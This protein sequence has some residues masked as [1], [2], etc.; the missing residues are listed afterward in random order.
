MDRELREYLAIQSNVRLDE[1]PHQYG[2]LGSV[3]PRGRPQADDPEFSK[4]PLPHPPVL[5]GVTHRPVD[6][7]GSLPD[8]PG[9][10]STETLGLLEDLVSSLAGFRPAFCAWHI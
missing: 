3:L 2:I 9:L 7:L 6:R 4:I 1:L 5:R 8:Q 10:G